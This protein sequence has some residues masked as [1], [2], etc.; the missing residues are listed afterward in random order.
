MR[1][2]PTT[3]MGLRAAIG[4]GTEAVGL[5]PGRMVGHAAGGGQRWWPAVL[6]CC[7]ATEGE[8]DEDGGR[9]RRRDG[10]EASAGEGYGPDG[11]GGQ[12]GCARAVGGEDDEHAGAGEAE[13]TGGE[14]HGKLGARSRH[15]GN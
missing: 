10:R 1:G 9:G 6:G 7:E 11:E 15:L 13:R 12:E 8:D 4:R 5:G 2:A 3:S 14:R